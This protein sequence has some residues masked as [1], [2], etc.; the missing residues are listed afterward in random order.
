MVDNEGIRPDLGMVADTNRAEQNGIRADELVMP[1]VGVPP[2]AVLSRPAR[3]T[4]GE[5]RRGP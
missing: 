1:D 5:A 2:A 4:E 3:V